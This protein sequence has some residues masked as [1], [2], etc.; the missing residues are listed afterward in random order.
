VSL[1][2]NGSHNGV[3]AVSDDTREQLRKR[4]D[5]R[6]AEEMARLG[7]PLSGEDQ[8]MLRQSLAAEA[9]RE[10]AA[11]RLASGRDLMSADEERQLKAEMVAEAVGVPAL[12]RYLAHPEVRDVDLNGPAVVHVTYRDG[13]RRQV[14]PIVESLAEMTD[15]IRQLAR[16][17]GVAL[18]G[19]PLE[20]DLT[21]PDGS[22][23]TV[24]MGKV[25]PWPVVSIRV[26]HVQETN[27][28]DLERWRMIPPDLKQVMVGL[29]RS[30]RNVVV[31]GGTGVGKTTFVASCAHE[32]PGDER[33]ITVEDTYELGLHLDGRHSDV[34]PLRTVRPNVE[35]VGEVTMLDLT[36]LALRLNPSR[37][38]VGEVRGGE[39]V[40]LLDAMTQ[41]NDGSW[42][43]VHA[44]SAMKVFSRLAKYAARAPEAPR[45]EDIVYD[46]ADALDVVVHLGLARNDRRPT[47]MSVRE[48]TGSVEAQVPASRELWAAGPDGVAR[49]TNVPMTG[50]L[51]NDLILAGVDPAVL[52]AEGTARR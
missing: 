7:R 41:G 25:A 29:A 19:A 2:G 35:G 14:A 1:N 17:A 51:A 39:C 46:I 31:G 52:A 32:V 45:R 10:E 16:L 5:V 22:R 20:I 8:T 26:H 4:I 18:E 50:E 48:V 13:T 43:T 47:V 9:L 30:R 49:R 34:V 28:S 24:A 42:C 3:A 40:S 21:L 27:L 23:V 38:F 15:M 6:L 11:A 33:I 37:V 12:Q 44:S 36:K